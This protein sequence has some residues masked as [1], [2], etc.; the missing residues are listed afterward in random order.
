[1]VYRP[2]NNNVEVG[3]AINK[4]IMD[5]CKSGTAIIMGDFNLHIDWL[6]QVGCVDLRKSS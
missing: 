2:P 4:Q 6:T 5:V 3:R 1:M